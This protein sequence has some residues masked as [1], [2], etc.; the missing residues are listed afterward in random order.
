VRAIWATHDTDPMF[1]G[2]ELVSMKWHGKEHRGVRSLHLLTP[3]VKNGLPRGIRA[4]HWEVTLRN[5]STDT[6][7]S[8][9]TYSFYFHTFAQTLALCSSWKQ[10]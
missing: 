9:F 3:P 8:G 7:L 6:Q 4:R 10:E 2:G 1:D 5:V